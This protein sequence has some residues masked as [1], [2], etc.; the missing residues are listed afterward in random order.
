MGSTRLTGYKR[1][2]FYMG[3]ELGVIS[4]K[5][6]Q[7]RRVFQNRALKKIFGSKR[8]VVTRGCGQ[9]YTEALRDLYFS[10]DISHSF[11]SLYGDKAAAASKASSPQSAI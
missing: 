1:R 9:L 4:L 11:R 6:D 8:E 3:L 7:R 2:L 5:D 10:G